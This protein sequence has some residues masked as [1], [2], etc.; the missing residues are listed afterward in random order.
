MTT[1]TWTYPITGTLPGTASVLTPLY[2]PFSEFNSNSGC[3][4]CTSADKITFNFN[5]NTVEN[6]DVTVD[7]IQLHQP[8]QNNTPIPGTIL[9]FGLGLLGLRGL[10][11][12]VK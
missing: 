3:L 8:P 9:L 12:Q 10:R 2:V 1:S 11:R 6:L 7:I 4:A 5:S